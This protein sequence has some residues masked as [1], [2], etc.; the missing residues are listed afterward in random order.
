MRVLCVALPMQSPCSRSPDPSGVMRPGPADRGNGALIGWALTPPQKSGIIMS[1][2]TD[3]QP[4]QHPRC[5][6]VVFPAALNGADDWQTWAFKRGKMTINQISN[7]NAARQ[8]LQIAASVDEV[9][10][11]R[12]KALA[13]E[14]YAMQAKDTAMLA[15]ATEIK[16][17][18]ER[19]AG[20]MLAAMQIKPGRPS[21]QEILVRNEDLATPILSDIGISYDQSANWQK[22][23]A[24]P[25]QQFEDAIANKS[26]S[27]ISTRSILKTINQSENAP[28]A[29][30]NPPEAAPDLADELAEAR[31]T[32]VEL[33]EE[34]E[35]LC[36]SAMPETELMAKVRAL[37]AELRVTR[38]QRDAYM[39]ENAELKRHNAALQ[40]KLKK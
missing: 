6:N 13:L 33:A 36:L 4:G 9:K 21:K 29:K 1:G 27:A 31:K 28:P 35:S 24:M 20:E 10:D 17:R 7:Y 8:A 25:E 30:S 38:Q 14:A 12:D 2:S 40:R 3:P 23:A 34:N 26:V 32:I 15:W 18:A 22:I 5:S 11:L 19:R 37:E 39:R 16:I